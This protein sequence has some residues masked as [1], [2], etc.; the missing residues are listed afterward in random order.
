M[1]ILRKVKDQQGKDIILELP[2]DWTDGLD[3][4]NAAAKE[5]FLKML[6]DG[7]AKIAGECHYY[8]FA[9]ISFLD[10]PYHYSILLNERDHID[11]LVMVQITCPAK[12][13]EQKQLPAQQQKMTDKK[14]TAMFRDLKIDETISIAWKEAIIKLRLSTAE[15]FA[16]CKRKL[17]E[18]IQHFDRLNKSAHMDSR[19][20]KILAHVNR[21]IETIQ[22]IMQHKNADLLTL[23]IRLENRAEIHYQAYLEKMNALLILKEQL[24]SLLQ[25][26]AIHH[27]KT[28]TKNNS[29][30]ESF[31]ETYFNDLFSGIAC[32]QHNQISSIKIDFTQETCERI[33][34]RFNRILG[35]LNTTYNRWMDGIYNPLGQSEPLATLTA[36]IAQFN[37]QYKT[38][39]S[40]I[41]FKNFAFSLQK[42]VYQ[43]ERETQASCAA[44]RKEFITAYDDILQTEAEEIF[45]IYSLINTEFEFLAKTRMTLANTTRTED[46]CIAKE[47]IV[48]PMVSEATKD[49]S[50]KSSCECFDRFPVMSP[51]T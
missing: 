15:E 39:V 4:P 16:K 51:H 30:I 3:L 19:I 31:A 18:T 17:P 42:N 40:P 29:V 8:Q 38:L 23:M 47:S 44:L 10:L 24:I 32:I 49:Q 41:D 22:V 6:L 25:Q 13:L 7:L 28:L 12:T 1:P 5:A 27:Y 50:E 48:T 43:F 20:E 37:T 35:I 14:Q 2:D 33:E 46:K 34:K 21:K 9:A 36:Y 11:C 45:G 26:T